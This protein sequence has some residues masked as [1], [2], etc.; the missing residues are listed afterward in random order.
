MNNEIKCAALLLAL[1][2]TPAYAENWKRIGPLPGGGVIEAD[3]ETIS[4]DKGHVYIFMRTTAP[5]HA[6]V[7]SMDDIDCRLQKYQMHFDGGKSPWLVIDP[8]GFHNA[9][10]VK[11]C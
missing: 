7:V 2:T 1:V 11:Y 4:K 8:S 6:P 3:Y 5:G 9:M 10:A